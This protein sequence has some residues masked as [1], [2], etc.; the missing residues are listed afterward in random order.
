MLNDYNVHYTH[1]NTEQMTKFLVNRFCFLEIGKKMGAISPPEY[2]VL[3][4]WYDWIEKK[5]DIDL[6]LIGNLSLPLFFLR[7]L[8]FTYPFV[9]C[10]YSV[11]TNS[12]RGGV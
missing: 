7:N 1:Y 12:P 2:A 5:M 4:E 6:D 8:H 11:L 9:P 3:T 10:D